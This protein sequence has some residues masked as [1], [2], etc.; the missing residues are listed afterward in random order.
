MGIN[1]GLGI[2]YDD[3]SIFNLSL[4]YGQEGTLSN[5]L[6]KNSY[7]VIYLSFSLYEL[8]STDSRHD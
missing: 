6:I 1:L 7:W 4:E 5:G 2:P 8:W 3:T